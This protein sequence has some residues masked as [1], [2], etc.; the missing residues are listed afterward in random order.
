MQNDRKARIKR[1]SDLASFEKKVRTS[2]PHLKPTELRV[3]RELVE[4]EQRMDIRR[5]GVSWLSKSGWI[6]KIHQ[7]SAT[8]FVF[9]L[10]PVV[11]QLFIEF[12]ENRFKEMVDQT[13]SNLTEP[14]RE[15]MKLFWQES[16]V[17]G[18]RESQNLMPHEIYQAGS[19]LVTLL[20]LSK[21]EWRE[22]GHLCE[23]FV[24][25]DYAKSRLESEIFGMPPVRIEADLNLEYVEGSR[26]TGGGARGRI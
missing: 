9:Q 16:I 3:L 4:S 10:S 14:Q 19:G 26:A 7:A 13:I 6:S 25:N 12:E 23:R 20:G 15:F 24:L 22:D 5:E 1:E 17:H 21:S 8:E 2:L 18:T 11:S